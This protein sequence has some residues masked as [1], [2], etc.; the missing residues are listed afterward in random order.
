MVYQDSD[1]ILREEADCRLGPTPNSPFCQQI[2]SQV[3][4]N[5]P[6]DLANPSGITSVMSLPINAA[7]DHT[8]GY[9]IGA[10]YLLSTGS[11][12][13]FDFNVAFTHVL[14][15]TIQLD[16]SDAV[17]NELTDWYD[18]VIP[19]APRRV[20]RRRGASAISRP[21][22]TDRIWVDCR[23]MTATSG[24]ARRRSTTDRSTTASISAAWRRCIVDNLFDTQPYRDST[25]TIYP[26]YASRWFNSVGTRVFPAIELP[27]RRQRRGMNVIRACADHALG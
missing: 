5:S 1:I 13:N 25:W 3:V 12:G 16:P 24:W 21:R 26:Y 6:N 27:I 10:H 8:S 22:Y 14:T 17:V 11:V 20:I 23:T 9:D 7:A 2:I 4:R 15:H 19:R 18:Y